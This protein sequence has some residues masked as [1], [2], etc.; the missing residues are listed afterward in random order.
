ESYTYGLKEK[1]YSNC[2]SDLFKFIRNALIH[3]PERGWKPREVLYA[4]Q[5]AFEPAIVNLQS[6]LLTNALID[7]KELNRLGGVLTS[8]E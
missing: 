8:T 3:V 5:L 1:A 6:Q 7:E 2:A 4:L